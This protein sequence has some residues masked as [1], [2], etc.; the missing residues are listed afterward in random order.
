MLFYNKLKKFYFYFYFYLFKTKNPEI[1]SIMAKVSEGKIKTI[2][3]PFIDIDLKGDS[4]VQV[5][6]TEENENKNKNKEKEK[7]EI[8][9][10]INNK[11]DKTFSTNIS[12]DK[13]TNM[14]ILI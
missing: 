2:R 3:T 10:N 6:V 8:L 14:G 1:V 7:N 11:N 12:L 5:T 9:L 13:S 4:M